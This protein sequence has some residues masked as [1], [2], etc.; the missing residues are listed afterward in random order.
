M[1]RLVKVRNIR[2]STGQIF[3]FTSPLSFASLPTANAEGLAIGRKD[4][5]PFASASQMTHD[6]T[7]PLGSVGRVHPEF[8]PVRKTITPSR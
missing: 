3:V 8:D 7:H 5:R 6:E 4:G 2:T 1:R